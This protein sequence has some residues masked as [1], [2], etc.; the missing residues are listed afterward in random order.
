MESCHEVWALHRQATAAKEQRRLTV[1]D[2]REAVV[3]GA[4]LRIR[5]ILMTAA[6]IIAG[7]WPIMVGTGTGSEVMRRIAAPMMGGMV[8]ALLLTL[9]VIPA[10]FLIWKTA[11]LRRAEKTGAVSEPAVINPV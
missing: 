5:P 7:L 1:N 9:L 3:E 6:T 4:L 8:S 10:T 11:A 2:V